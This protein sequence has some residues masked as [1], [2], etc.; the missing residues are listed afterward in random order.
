MTAPAAGLSASVVP[1]S[2]AMLPDWWSGLLPPGLWK[3]PKSF[4]T[5]VLQYTPFPANG[6]PTSATVPVLPR[7]ILAGKYFALLFGGSATVV[8]TDGITLIQPFGGVTSKKLIRL[9]VPAE[10]DILTSG[11]LP[12]E[13][14][15]SASA[16]MDAD[17]N[18]V[19]PFGTAASQAAMWPLP[20]ILRPGAALQVDMTDLGG[21]DANVWLAFQG[22]QISAEALGVAA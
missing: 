5:F 10:Q 9:S 8:S 3:R 21:L 13:N 7:T 22:C 19:G 2:P 20:I 1:A 18:G 11:F 4:K 17:I 16:A 14:V 12:L 6:S 15:L